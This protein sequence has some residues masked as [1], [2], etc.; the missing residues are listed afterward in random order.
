MGLKLVGLLSWRCHS[1]V[2]FPEYLSTHFPPTC[3]QPATWYIKSAFESVRSSLFAI[4]S[5][6][7]TMTRTTIWCWLLEFLRWYYRKP[8]KHMQDYEINK[9]DLDTRTADHHL[10]SI[11]ALN[12]SSVTSCMWITSRKAVLSRK[13]KTA[14]YGTEAMQMN[15]TAIGTGCRKICYNFNMEAPRLPWRR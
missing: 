11:G 13:T 14:L 4:L 3:R 9:F 15:H 1:T 5:Q 6:Q 8:R 12:I 10:R 7:V 2:L